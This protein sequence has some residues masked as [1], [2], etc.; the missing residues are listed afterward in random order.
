[1]HSHRAHLVRNKTK[2][3][4]SLYPCLLDKISCFYTFSPLSGSQGRT[5]GAAAEATGAIDIELI[6][7][8]RGESRLN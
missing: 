3:I 5:L 1:M 4:C 2:T 6:T 8:S 7:E